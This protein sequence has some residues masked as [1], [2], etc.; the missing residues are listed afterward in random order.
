MHNAESQRR[1]QNRY[2]RIGASA[3][4]LTGNGLAK[5]QFLGNRTHNNQCEQ[6]PNVVRHCQG[7]LQHHIWNLYCICQDRD[8]DCSTDAARNSKYALAPSNGREI[9]NCINTNVMQEKETTQHSGNIHCH[10]NNRYKRDGQ[11]FEQRNALCRSAKVGLNCCVEFGRDQ[12]SDAEKQ[13]CA[14]SLRKKENQQR[15]NGRRKLFQIY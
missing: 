5:E 14:N 12:H 10:Q 6:A 4:H 3:Q 8:T 2:P 15:K 1:N 11:Q 13:N 7:G 9:A